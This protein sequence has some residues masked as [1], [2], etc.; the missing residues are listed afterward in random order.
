[1]SSVNMGYT[2]THIHLVKKIRH[3]L[4]YSLRHLYN[5]TMSNMI[6]NDS[7]ITITKKYIYMYS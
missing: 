3:T 1:M 6:E 7:G 2:G 5:I 4:M